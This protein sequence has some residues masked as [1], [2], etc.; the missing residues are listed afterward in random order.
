[1]NLVVLIGNLGKDAETR[2]TPGGT[3]VSN[4]SV[5]TSYK[6]KEGDEQTE[7]HN[8]VLWKHENLAKYLVKGKKVS[9]QGRLQTRKWEDKDGNT[10]YTTEVV[11]ERIQLLGSKGDSQQSGGSSQQGD[12]GPQDQGIDD[13]DVP[14]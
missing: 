9:I 14:F 1:M 2:F 5:A 4:F 8:V 7:W 12:P 6:P 11:A 13:D 3:A 10:R